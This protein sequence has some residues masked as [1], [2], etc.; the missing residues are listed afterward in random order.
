MR[1]FKMAQIFFLI[2]IITALY[3]GTQFAFLFREFPNTIYSD[4]RFAV[5]VH[6]LRI[7][8]FLLMVIYEGA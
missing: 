5:L 3:K 4:S 6:M 8:K 2:N 7:R 1:L